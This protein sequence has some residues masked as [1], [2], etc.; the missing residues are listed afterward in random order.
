MRGMKSKFRGRLGPE[1]EDD[2]SIRILNRIVEW[3]EAGIRYEADQR[4]AELIVKEMGFKDGSKS[5]TTPGSK[6]EREE[7]DGEEELDMQEST[8]YRAT[9]ARAVYLTQDRT[10]I[11]FATKELARRMSKPRVKDWASLK[12]MVMYLIGKE[13]SGMITRTHIRKLM[14]G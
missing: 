2:K 12:R 6:S 1:K 5:V 14:C 11:G 8:R 3:T 7:E 9:V 10:D 13:L 4:H